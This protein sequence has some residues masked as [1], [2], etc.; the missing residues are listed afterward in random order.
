MGVKLIVHLF[1]QVILALT[2]AMVVLRWS[3]CM[4]TSLCTVTRSMSY[5]S[6]QK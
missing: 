4:T 1:S 3:V 5:P 2:V 6:S